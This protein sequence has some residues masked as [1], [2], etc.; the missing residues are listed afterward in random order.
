[1]E[2]TSVLVKILFLFFAVISLGLAIV[3]CSDD[4]E[5]CK[6]CK[7]EVKGLFSM[8]NSSYHFEYGV[9]RKENDGAFILRIYDIDEEYPDN[10]YIRTAFYICN[11]S[12]LNKIIKDKASTTDGVKVFF[13]RCHSCWDIYF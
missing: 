6:D 10:R 11:P 2:R 5:D 8:P 4:D 12:K 7:T 1:M 9:I 13:F 3:S